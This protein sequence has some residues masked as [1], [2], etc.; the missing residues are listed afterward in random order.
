MKYLLA[1][2]PDGDVSDGMH[3]R[4]WGRLREYALKAVQAQTQG[5]PAHIQPPPIVNPTGP[6]VG[7]A[8]VR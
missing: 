2:G 5:Q 6:H 4:R 8:H 7:M 3:T 1:V